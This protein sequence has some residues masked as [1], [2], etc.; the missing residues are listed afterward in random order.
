L[1]FLGR[2]ISEQR[3]YSEQTAQLIDREVKKIIEE[4]YQRAKDILTQ[5]QDK[6]VAV[7]KRLIE[8][9]TLDEAELEALLA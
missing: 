4:A 2:E 7:A 5:Y 3:D 1:I 8:V 6:L 9:E